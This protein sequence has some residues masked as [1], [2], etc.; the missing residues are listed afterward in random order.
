[1]KICPKCNS[2][3]VN[4][5]ITPSAVFGAPQ[6]WKC[7]DCGFEAYAVFPDLEKLD[8]EEKTEIKKGKKSME[9]KVRRK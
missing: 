8:E 2:A 1:M 5:N 6:K 4:I 3:N 9:K 7:D